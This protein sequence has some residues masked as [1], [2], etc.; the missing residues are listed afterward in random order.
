VFLVGRTP[1]SY[2]L[3]AWEHDLE[4]SMVAE[5]HQTGKNFPSV[6]ENVIHVDEMTD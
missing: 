4:I 3:H 2:L 5:N 1:S 6:T